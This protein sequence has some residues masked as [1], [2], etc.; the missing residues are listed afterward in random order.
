MRQRTVQVGPDPR[1]VAQILRLAVAAVEPGEGAEQARVSLRR[2]DGVK[3]GE[4][5]GIELPVGCAARLDVA[6]QQRQF[7]LLGD[8]D[9]RVLQQR[10]QIV[11]GGAQH[12]ILEVD[13]ADA[14][15]PG[16]IV[17]PDEV[18]RMK[19]PHHPGPWR[20]RRLLQQPIATSR[21][22][23]SRCSA[24]SSAPR[25]GRVP[26]E[27]QPDLDQP[28]IDIEDGNVVAELRRQRQRF[29]QRLAMQRRPAYRSRPR[30]AR[31][32]AAADRLR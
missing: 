18:G 20:G 7:E 9:P 26:F 30:S 2:H 3:L 8:V 28:R 24:L 21:R 16:A 14:Q 29:G 15:D 10:H 32:S 1:L 5:G 27:H 31:R 11:G 23:R 22:I 12:G 19:I 17:E 6:G 25:S 4:A 13:D